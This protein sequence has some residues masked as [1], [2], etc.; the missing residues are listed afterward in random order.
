MCPQ[1][2]KKIRSPNSTF[3]A[4]TTIGSTLVGHV[5]EFTNGF[6]TLIILTSHHAC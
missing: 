1:S 4:F 5:E 2:H 3:H 6:G